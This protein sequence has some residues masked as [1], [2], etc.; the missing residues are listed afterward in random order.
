MKNFVG[1]IADTHQLLRPDA[2]TAL[3]GADLII[4]AGDV[5][6]P[7]ILTTF[8]DIAPLYVVRG[9]VAKAPGLW[10]YRLQR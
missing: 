5:G 1:V 7:E 3:Q 4:H 9:N 10:R 6:K 2:V 8:R